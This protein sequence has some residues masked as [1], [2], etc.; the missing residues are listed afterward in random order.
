MITKGIYR[1]F[2]GGEYEVIGVAVH[3]ETEE[4][5]VLYREVKDPTGIIWARPI[6]MWDEIVDGEK[7][8]EKIEP[9]CVF[10]T[11]EGDTI[12]REAAVEAVKFGCTYAKLINKETGEV[13]ELF[14]RENEELLRAASRIIALPPAEP[15]RGYWMQTP[16]QRARICSCCRHDEPYKF[17]EDDVDIYNFCPHC[18]SDMRGDKYA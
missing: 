15:R 14:S 16:Y 8:F 17:A 18:G 9:E 11:N 4:G 6:E 13:R 12:Y 1:H 5:L 7:R 3:T 2:K 10:K